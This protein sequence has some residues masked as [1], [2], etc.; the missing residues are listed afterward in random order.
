LGKP[1]TVNQ[2]PTLPCI[3]THH[4][5]GTTIH[6]PATTR[7][8][9]REQSIWLG[10]VQVC[11][12]TS[13]ARLSTQGST[14]STTTTISITCTTRP[15]VAAQL[16]G[17]IFPAPIRNMVAWEYNGCVPGLSI[18]Q[19]QTH[20]H[21]PPILVPH[22]ARSA[23]WEKDNVWKGFAMKRLP[24]RY[25]H[26]YCQRCC[27]DG[28]NNCL[29]FPQTTDQRSATVRKTHNRP[30]YHTPILRNGAHRHLDCNQSTYPL[31]P[32]TT[33]QKNLQLGVRDGAINT[34]MSE[35]LAI[36]TDDLAYLRLPLALPTIPPVK[37]PG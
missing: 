4:L 36:P 17:Q 25:C 10:F 7:S 33:P 9:A 31:H 34:T 18:R 29:T 5:Q 2:A 21:A 23:A 8:A 32:T 30:L 22:A 19:W 16:D 26:T 1:T 15:F 24:H 35:L 14:T 27:H 6:L 13:R 11:A 37:R 20:L 3:C 28:R 12:T